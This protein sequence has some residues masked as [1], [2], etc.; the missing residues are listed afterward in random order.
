MTSVAD[1]TVYLMVAD[2]GSAQ[3]TYTIHRVSADGSVD[4][5]ADGVGWVTADQ[6]HMFVL[7]TNDG[8]GYNTF[9]VLDLT[10]DTQSAPISVSTSYDGE[11]RVFE[12][13]YLAI[14]Y[15]AGSNVYVHILDVDGNATDFV[16]GADDFE[17]LI[18]LDDQFSVITSGG[19][20]TQATLIRA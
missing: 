8:S 17:G 20:Y 11:F 18:Y 6:Q 5:L 7:R 16:I 9:S 4:D 13:K 15:H 1:G 14:A 19:G 2:P 3:N 12:G 10:T